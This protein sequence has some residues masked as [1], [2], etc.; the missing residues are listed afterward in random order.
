MQRIKAVQISN[1]SLWIEECCEGTASYLAL[2][3]LEQPI[4]CVHVIVQMVF[5]IS[6]CD[7]DG[8]HEFYT[9]PLQFLCMRGDYNEMQL[10]VMQWRIICINSRKLQ[11]QLGH[12]NTMHFS[13]LYSYIV[14][15]QAL[16]NV[17]YAHTN[18]IS[19]FGLGLAEW[20]NG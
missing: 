9:A 19:S 18:H 16:M 5:G 15:L 17:S 8:Y 3:R 13:N 6:L 10:L 4:Q 7:S 14:C 20:L 1:Q 11:A 12:V 2:L